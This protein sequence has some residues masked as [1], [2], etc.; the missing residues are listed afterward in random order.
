MGYATTDPPLL[1]FQGDQ[2]NVFVIDEVV[3]LIIRAI[4]YHAIEFLL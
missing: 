2:K 3:L 1:Q 4:D